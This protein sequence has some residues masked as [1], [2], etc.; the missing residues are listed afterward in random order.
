MQTKAFT[1][2]RTAFSRVSYLDLV[3]IKKLSLYFTNLET[4]VVSF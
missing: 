2:Q 4:K 3:N 1:K